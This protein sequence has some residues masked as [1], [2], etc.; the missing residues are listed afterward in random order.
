MKLGEGGTKIVVAQWLAGPQSLKVDGGQSIL[1]PWFVKPQVKVRLVLGLEVLCSLN[2]GCSKTEIDHCLRGQQGR[3]LSAI[4]GNCE[5][6]A[7][8]GMEA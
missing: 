2:C 1:F 4:V 5:L 6:D 8:F 7:N 3:R